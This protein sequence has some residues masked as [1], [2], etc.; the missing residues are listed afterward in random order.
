MARR[1]EVREPLLI[2]RLADWLGHRSR[3]I[4]TLIAGGVAVVLT[5]AL[6]LTLVG[7]LLNTPPERL[8][9][10]PL[11]AS[12]VATAL[13]VFLVVAGFAF[14]WVGWR[15]L[16][17]F[18]FEDSPLQPGRPAALWVMLGILLLIVVLFAS[19][20]LLIAALQ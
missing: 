4:R 8:S 13:F 10:G 15:V 20:L 12:G 11:D 2:D 19:G 9:F 17:G 5:I 7:M 1:P 18:D 3:P 16:I 6:A 14:Y